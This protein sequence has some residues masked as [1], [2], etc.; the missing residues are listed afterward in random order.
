MAH[1]RYLDT[2]KDQAWKFMQAMCVELIEENEK[3]RERVNAYSRKNN[4]P[5]G[6]RESTSNSLDG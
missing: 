1:I 6:L 4:E 5:E 3:L 2:E